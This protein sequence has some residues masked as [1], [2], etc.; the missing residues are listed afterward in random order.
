MRVMI[1]SGGSPTKFVGSLTVPRTSL[2]AAVFKDCARCAILFFFSNKEVIAAPQMERRF[3]TPVIQD[4]AG[5]ECGVTH[6][7]EH[8][9]PEV[10][11][12]KVESCTGTARLYQNV[13]RN[14][15]LAK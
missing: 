8:K 9:R 13:V 1:R 7:E 10:N 11:L 12:G 14:H 4:N 3:P 5:F 6:S 2:N 15:S